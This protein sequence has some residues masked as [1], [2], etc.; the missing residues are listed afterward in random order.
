LF[1]GLI[2]QAKLPLQIT[3]CERDHTAVA[4]YRSRFANTDEREET[5]C[6]LQIYVV[7]NVPSG[8]VLVA[9]DGR[10]LGGVIHTIASAYET[11]IERKGAS[12]VERSKGCGRCR[13]GLP[14]G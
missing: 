8:V 9:Y 10:D 1:E 12:R 13:S 7:R 3:R 2:S 6:Y 11:H 14:T 4:G 5:Y